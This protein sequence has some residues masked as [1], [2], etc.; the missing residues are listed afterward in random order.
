MFILVNSFLAATD[1]SRLQ[2]SA[3]STAAPTQTTSP[4]NGSP[5]LVLQQGKDGRDGVNGRDGRDGLPGRA[6]EKGDPGV[7]GPP[8]STGPQGKSELEHRKVT[9]LGAKIF[10]ALDLQVPLVPVWVVQCTPGGGGPHV[11]TS[12]EHN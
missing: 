3:E 6:G 4:Y 9:H 10:F 11:Q 7:Q 1:I 5:F 2:R 12:L 8:G